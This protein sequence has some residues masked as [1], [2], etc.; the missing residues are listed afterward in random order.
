MVF[1]YLHI[2]FKNSTILCRR[3]PTQKGLLQERTEHTSVLDQ[4][5]LFFVL[6]LTD[7]DYFFEAQT[8]SA[9]AEYLIMCYL[10]PAIGVL[11]VFFIPF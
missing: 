2:K 7:Q 11:S 1:R 4:P 3:P 5:E 6:C 9:C 10:F 8:K